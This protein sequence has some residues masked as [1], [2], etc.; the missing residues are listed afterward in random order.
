MSQEIT[1]CLWCGTQNDPH[2]RT[3]VLD[4]QSGILSKELEKR[5]APNQHL[6]QIVL[7]GL[8]RGGV[9]LPFL[10]CLQRLQITS[11]PL[12][13]RVTVGPVVTTWRS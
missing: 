4:Q 2:Q 1:K 8:A 11:Q 3:T 5:I 9:Q 10:A 6:N 7:T 12:N 13:G